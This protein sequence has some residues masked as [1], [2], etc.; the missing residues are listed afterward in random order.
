MEAVRD[1]WDP[2]NLSLSSPPP[3]PRPHLP[4]VIHYWPFQGSTFIVLVSVNCYVVFNFLMFFYHD[5]VRW[6]YIKWSLGNRALTYLGKSCQLSLLMAMLHSLIARR[7]FGPLTQWQSLRNTLTSGLGL[8]D[9]SLVWPAV[10]QQLVFI[11][12]GIQ[13]WVLVFVYYSD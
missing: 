7:R 13:P 8:D 5:S 3:L 10:V 2:V 9:M 1:S 12:S 6:L 11:Y 4:P